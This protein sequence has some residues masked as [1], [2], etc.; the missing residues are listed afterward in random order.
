ML[1]DQVVMAAGGGGATLIFC[2]GPRR[3]ALSAAHGR[4]DR[5]LQLA[6]ILE[7][8]RHFSLRLRSENNQTPSLSVSPFLAVRL[9]GFSMPARPWK[10]AAVQSPPLR[11]SRGAMQGT[12]LIVYIGSILGDISGRG[13]PYDTTRKCP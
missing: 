5:R 13:A 12:S 3:W 1:E 6:S 8:W 11:L 10:G 7:P 2:Q 9:S 4:W